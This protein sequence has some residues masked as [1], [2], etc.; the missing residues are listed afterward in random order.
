MTDSS[1][2][3]LSAAAITLTLAAQPVFGQDG[4]PLPAPRPVTEILHGVEIVDR[5]RFL[6][7]VSS[8]E[9]RRFVADE[10]AYTQKL[11]GQVPGR[12]R[13]RARIE[14]LVMAG[15]VVDVEL[16]GKLTFYRQRTGTQ[17]QPLLYVRDGE[18][19]P[20]LL[21][22]VNGLSAAGTVALDWYVPSPDGRYLAYGLSPNGSEIST[23]HVMDVA[24][25]KDMGEAITPTRT[26]GIAWKHDGSGFYYTRP[27]AGRVPQGKELYDIRVYWHRLGENLEGDGDALVFGEGLGL[28]ETHIPRPR[29][30]EDDR[31]LTI[32]VTHGPSRND[33]WLQDL[34][35]GTPAQLLTGGVEGLFRPYVHRGMLYVLTNEGASHYRLMRAEVARPDRAHWQEIVPAGEAVLTGATIVGDSWLLSYNQDAT[36]RFALT[37]LDGRNRRDVAMPGLGSVETVAGSSDRQDAYF[38][39][40]SF[41]TPLT[42]YRLDSAQA[43][44]EP[45]IKL[46]AGAID[47]SMIEVRQLFYPSKDGTRVPMFVI[48]RKGVKLDGENPTVLYGYGGFNI[49]S[50]PAFNPRSYDWAS[51][52]GV[53]CVANLRGGSEYGEAW[54]RAGMLGNKQNVFDDFIA[55]AEY[56]IRE[57]W[58]SPD[59]LAVSGR[60]NGGLLV[61]AA[62]TQRP[63]LFRAAISGVP[64]LDMLRYDQFSIAKLWVPEWGSAEDPEQFKWL[65]AY[66][67][68]HHVAPGTLYPATLFFTA[69]TDTRVAPLHALKM[70]ALMQAD[71][72]NGADPQRPILLRIERDAGHGQGMPLA[73]QID[74]IT[75]ELTFLD[76]QLGSPNNP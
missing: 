40:Q 24:T 76:W 2:S 67:P 55:A 4:P 37:D 6:E 74:G 42:A 70:T 27:R 73:K 44:S 19:A 36:A 8:A 23:L 60:S 29:L 31:W 75:D 10:M 63:E 21:L 50:T 25:G 33:L 65:Y 15:Q 64:V 11:L 16:G 47:P 48:A 14:A 72:Q 41:D 1:S 3:A 61:G 62:I 5:Y 45:W 13:L 22:D 32:T 43:R 38:V 35:S 53:W 28:A 66:S 57:K 54:H 20:R 59:R 18:G 30:S 49:S 12:D 17:N 71:A 34:A 68:Y 26:A 51:Q 9:T 7:D 52:G 69:D 56:L 46:D 58:T 39:Y